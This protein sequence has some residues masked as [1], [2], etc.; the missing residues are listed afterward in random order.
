MADG[1]INFVVEENDTELP[2]GISKV[3][4]FVVVDDDDDDDD[5]DD[6]KDAHRMRRTNVL[7]CCR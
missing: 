5:D 4:S 3:N 2:D 7:S 6:E 1:N